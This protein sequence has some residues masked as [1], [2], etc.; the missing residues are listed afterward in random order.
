[1]EGSSGGGV[2]HKDRQRISR[3]RA[4]YKKENRDCKERCRLKMEAWSDCSMT[5]TE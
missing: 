1:M 5:G 4:I 3:G 2:A